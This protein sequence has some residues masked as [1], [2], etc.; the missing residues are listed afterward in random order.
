MEMVSKLL[1]EAI[2]I[3]HVE[4]ENHE[5]KANDI[6]IVP[7]LFLARLRKHIA[8]LLETIVSL[9]DVLDGC[10]QISFGKLGI[11][12]NFETISHVFSLILVDQLSLL[13]FRVSLL[14][15]VV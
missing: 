13:L 11:N 10:L 6:G 7:H 14:V 1:D 12:A 5:L 9:L 4:E 2:V 15:R 3:L 8:S